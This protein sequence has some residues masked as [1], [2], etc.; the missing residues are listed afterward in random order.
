[1]KF[2]DIVTGF[3]ND[4]LLISV[5]Y[6]HLRQRLQ[7]ETLFNKLQILTTLQHFF[8]RL[9]LVTEYNLL[10]F[11]ILFGILWVIWI[12]P[13]TLII[14]IVECLKLMECEFAGHVENLA[15]PRIANVF[16]ALFSQTTI[17]RRIK[18]FDI[19]IQLVG[20]LSGLPVSR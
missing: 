16:V 2:E 6:N 15:L 7:P 18:L 17:I 19:V 11:K 13:A 9:P 3:S 1:M 20:D 5:H 12:D 10:G 4:N 8:S 14:F